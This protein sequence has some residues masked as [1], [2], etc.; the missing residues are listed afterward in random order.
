MKLTEDNYYSQ[1]ANR[2]YM[3]VSQF[4]DFNRCEAQAL[5]KLNGEHEEAKADCFIIGSYVGAAIEGDHAFKK[6]VEENPGIFSSRGE[7]KGELKADY[8]KADVMVNALMS[9]PLCKQML[10]GDKEVIVIAELYG[11]MWKAKLDV[12]NPDE[13]RIVDLKTAKGIRERYWMDGK[14]VSFIENFGYVLQ[15]AVYSELER[16]YNDRFESLEPMIVAVSKEDVPDKAVICFDE[17]S[18]RE[19]LMMVQEK[20]PRIIAVKEGLEEPKRCGKCR[21]CRKT[22]Q[23]NG[24]IHYLDL[25]EG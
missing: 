10:E 22:K 8:K 23:V 24:L 4:K 15:M 19:E 1:E 21:Y 3:S 13:G 18:L 17:Q 25:L 7:T 12:H 5:A 20:L 11:V 14:W 2:Y 9:D 16:I 6:F